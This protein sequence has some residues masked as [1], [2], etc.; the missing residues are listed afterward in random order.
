[1]NPES[2][3]SH[4]SPC[5]MPPCSRILIGL[6]SK[7][8]PLLLQL[9]LQRPHVPAQCPL[10]CTVLLLRQLHDHGALRFHLRQAALMLVQQVLHLLLVD[11]GVREC[12]CSPALSTHLHTR[13]LA[14]AHRLAC[15]HRLTCTHMPTCAPLHDFSSAHIG[16]HAHLNI[17]ALLLKNTFKLPMSKDTKGGDPKA[18]HDRA[19][20]PRASSSA[21]GDSHGMGPAPSP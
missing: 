4:L 13:M 12:R 18:R 10:L 7:I 2:I 8:D 11:L 5:P 15:T 14:C 17:P 6:T 9:H 20:G 1:M 16:S 19:P 3:T 21:R